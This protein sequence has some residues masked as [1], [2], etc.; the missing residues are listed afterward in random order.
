MDCYFVTR[1]FDLW[2][3]AFC[4]FLCCPLAEKVVGVLVDAFLHR[5][6]VRHTFNLSLNFP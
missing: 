3:F 6:H 2:S 1:A 5:S 4:A